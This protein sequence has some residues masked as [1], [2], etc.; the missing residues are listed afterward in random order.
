MGL[1]MMQL[2]F[3][4]VLTILAPFI[5]KSAMKP[6]QDMDQYTQELVDRRMERGYDPKTV[7]VFNYL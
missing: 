4:G 1:Q 5:P 7:D 3:Y 2:Q 6:K